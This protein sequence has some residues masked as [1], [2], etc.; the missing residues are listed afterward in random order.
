MTEHGEPPSEGARRL[1][2]AQRVAQGMLHEFRNILNPI[3]SA[4]YLMHANAHDPAKVREL[5]TRIEGF[6]RAEDR[7]ATKMRELLDREAS[8]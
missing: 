3:V 7:V 4:A 2:S 1:E 8:G 6:A 5:A